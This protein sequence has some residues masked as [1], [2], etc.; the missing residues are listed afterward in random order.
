MSARDVLNKLKWHPDYDISTAEI[1]VLHRGAPRDKKTISG[2]QIQNIGSGFIKVKGSDKPVKI[3]Y[4][5]VLKIETP[6]EVLFREN[7]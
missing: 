6:K 3:P 7:P 1:T 4:H 5:R 2:K